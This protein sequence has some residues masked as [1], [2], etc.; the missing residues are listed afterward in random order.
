MISSIFSLSDAKTATPEDLAATLL[1]C[2][3]E[4][5]I[6]RTRNEALLSQIERMRKNTLDIVVQTEAEE[7]AISNRLMRRAEQLAQAR[8][9]RTAG[10][11]QLSLLTFKLSH[12]FMVLY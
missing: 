2:R 8:A 4:L 10:L 7:E 1:A 6:E 9:C 11:P 12:H 5:H 3:N